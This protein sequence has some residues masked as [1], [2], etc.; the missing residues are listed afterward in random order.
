MVNQNIDEFS[1]LINPEKNIPYYITGITGITN[2]MVDDAPKFYEIAKDI[3]EITENCIIVGHNINFDYNFI[4]QEFKNLGYQWQRERIDTIKLARKLIPGHKSYSL[5]KIC[6][7]LGINNNARHRAA[8]DALATLELFKLLIEKNKE[9]NIINEISSLTIKGLNENFDITIIKD[10]PEEP[11]VYFFH[12]A[13]YDIIYTGKSKNINKRIK[14]HLT[15][16][17]TKRILKM[18]GEIQSISFELTGSDLVASLLESHYIKKHKP[19]YNRAQRRTGNNYGLTINKNLDGYFSLQIEKL[20]KPDKNHACCFESKKDAENYLRKIISEYELCLSLTNYSNYTG[21]C[22][23]YQVGLCRG[24][25]VG[26]ELPDTYNKRVNKAI[27]NFSVGNESFFIVEKGRSANEH[28]IVK[29]EKGVYKGFGF[30]DNNLLASGDNSLIEDIIDYYD[31]NR[32]VHAIINSYLAKSKK[33][34]KIFI[35]L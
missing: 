16:N 1:S 14:Q 3:V 29:I 17:D 2:E 25:C 23:N 31:N 10:L 8:G 9:G 7:E 20:T 13:N 35:C 5:G 18:K 34:K 12:N 19:Q 15:K 28:A 33:I 22:F 26:E 4:K 21:P 11:G 30:A 6:P 27:E 24:A 32:E